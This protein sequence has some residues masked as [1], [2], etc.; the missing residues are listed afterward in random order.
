MAKYV[1]KTCCQW[2][3]TEQEHEIEG[4]FKNEDEA[5]K[6]FG[7]DEEAWQQAIEDHA[8]ECWI[9]LAEE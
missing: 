9:E 8:P 2:A 5:L 3:G 4:D 6:A 1:L 7:G